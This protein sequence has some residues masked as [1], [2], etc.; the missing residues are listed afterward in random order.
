MAAVRQVAS[1]RQIQPEDVLDSLRHAM[2]A[3]YR[4]D[5]PGESLEGVEVELDPETGE[6]TL[7]RE[8]KDITPPGFGRIAAQTAKQVILQGVRESEKKAILRSFRQKVGSVISGMLQ[9]VERGTW[10]VDLGRATALMPRVEQVFSEEYHHN[11][12]L[13]VYIKEVVE[14]ERRADIIVS[15]ADPRL[16]V[17]LFRLEVPEIQSGAVEVKGIAREPGSRSKIAVISRQEGVDPVGSLVGQRGV[18]VNAVT[19]ELNGEKMD[20]ILWDE[21][22]TTFIKNA[23]SPAK[24]D[25]VRLMDEERAVVEV[26]EDQLSL[27]IGKGG[28]N[29]R[30]A[31]KLTGFALEVVGAE[32]G[33]VEG[34][35]LER[36]AEGELVR[37]A[38]QLKQ[39]GLPTR[40]VNVLAR[41][42]VTT[43]EELKEMSDE[44]LGKIKGI[45]PESVKKIRELTH[46]K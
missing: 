28:Q 11:Q 24:V 14:D 35:E 43:W 17:E 44:E 9:R 36:E 34:L 26:S 41:A 1:E 27:A 8:G 38:A 18:R 15:R 46:G 33:K 30:L 4:K 21:D 23:L 20:I 29:V 37:D 6:V 31:A 32:S 5:H 22:P 45:G 2:L 42:G 19:S 3:A 10:V 40:L 12:R 16:V 7:L 25:R 39:I 13:K